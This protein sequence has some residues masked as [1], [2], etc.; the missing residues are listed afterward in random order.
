VDGILEKRST[1]S[2][3]HLSNNRNSVS[4]IKKEEKKKKE[5]S[6]DSCLFGAA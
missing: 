4:E 2:D 5:I 6:L 1:V 3:R